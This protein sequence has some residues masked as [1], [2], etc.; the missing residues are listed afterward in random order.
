[1]VIQIVSIFYKVVKYY[2]LPLCDNQ[3]ILLRISPLHVDIFYMKAT[4]HHLRVIA[5]LLSIQ[6]VGLQQL[7]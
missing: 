3:I 2:K 4:L 7:P 5:S 1:M 6:S